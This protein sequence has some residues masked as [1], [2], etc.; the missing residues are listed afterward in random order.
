MRDR[1]GRSQV[2]RDLLAQAWRTDGARLGE[3][4]LSFP[5]NPYLLV[6]AVGCIRA[7]EA[8]GFELDD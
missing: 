7:G 4:W 1:K 3:S 2:G 6:L 8:W 5:L